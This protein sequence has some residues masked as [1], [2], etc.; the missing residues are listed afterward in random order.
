MVLLHLAVLVITTE[1]RVYVCLRAVYL[2]RELKVIP[3][4][5]LTQFCSFGVLR[6]ALIVV[7]DQV[8]HRRILGLLQTH[9]IISAQR[10]HLV[11]L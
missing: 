2:H 6:R 10:I 8:I 3:T 1:L 7:V 11:A 9:I 5:L 4:D